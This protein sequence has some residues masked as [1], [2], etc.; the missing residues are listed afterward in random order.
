MDVSAR[1]HQQLTICGIKDRA[2]CPDDWVAPLI[3]RIAA[4]QS[5]P[6][7]PGAREAEAIAICSGA[8]F[9]GVARPR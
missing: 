3:G 5:D 1:I 8:F 6:P 7:C 9:G 2:R 4:G